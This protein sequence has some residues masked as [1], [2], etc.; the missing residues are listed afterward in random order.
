MNIFFKILTAFSFVAVFLTFFTGCNNDNKSDSQTETVQTTSVSATANSND[1]ITANLNSLHSYDLENGNEF[2]GAW[3]I[4]DGEGNQFESFVY[5]FD[6][7]ETA[8]IVIDTMGYIGKYSITT[9]DNDEKIF[10]SQL[11]FGING[12]YTFEVAE[13][14]NTIILTNK[15]TSSKTT[16]ERI[17]S[18]N[19]IPISDTNS[20]I[21]TNLLGAW[22]SDDAEYYYFDN[23]GIMYQNQ[24]GSIFTYFTYSAENS[25]ITATYSMGEKETDSYEYSIQGDT[26]TLNGYNYKKIPASELI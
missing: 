10:S 18:F 8:S 25:I 19:C 13:D 16:L 24:Y 6:G 4:A 21:D 20:K 7:K 17:S 12:N 3:K 14:E 5:L 9:D 1:D 2:A 26:L 23:S 11:M 15:D 22:K